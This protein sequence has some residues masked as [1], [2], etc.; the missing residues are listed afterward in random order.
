MWLVSA[1]SPRQSEI[2]RG[3]WSRPKNDL[4]LYALELGFFFK[5]W[6]CYQNQYVAKPV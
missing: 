3:V 6:E 1:M 5:S 2:F 4:S